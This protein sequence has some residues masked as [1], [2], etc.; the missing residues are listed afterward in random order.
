MGGGGEAAIR[1]GASKTGNTMLMTAATGKKCL[2]RQLTA[3][4]A[5]VVSVRLSAAVGVLSGKHS[6]SQTAIS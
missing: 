1:R 2:N 4:T 3:L 5:M 6:E